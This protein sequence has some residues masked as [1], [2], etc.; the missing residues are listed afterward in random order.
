MMTWEHTLALQTPLLKSRPLSSHT[1]SSQPSLIRSP[2]VPPFVM[3]EIV[4]G[5]QVSNPPALYYRPVSAPITPHDVETLRAMRVAS[6][7]YYERIPSWINEIAT[8]QR[9]M[10]FIY[11]SDPLVQALTAAA[12]S[13]YTYQ[14]PSSPYGAQYNS[15]SSSSSGS[16]AAALYSATASSSSASPVAV[17]PPVGMV[18]ISFNN[19]QDPSLASFRMTGRCEICSLFVY[20]AYRPLG[21]GAAAIQNMEE[22]ARMMGAI[23]VTMNT[24]AVERPLRKYLAMGYREYKPRSRVYSA[25]DVRNA[26]LPEDY[27]TAAF[28]EK[29]LI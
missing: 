17:Y 11:L 13:T 22:R 20:A 2:T 29:S 26:G 7:W 24:P 6:G 14:P 16:S 25:S 4:Q 23:F 15:A 27:E 21:I 3:E 5:T 8:G 28:L 9:L 19:P 18:C 12:E 1:S 10:W